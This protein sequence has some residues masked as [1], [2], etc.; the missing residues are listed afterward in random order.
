[1]KAVSDQL[2]AV[3][4]ISELAADRF[5]TIR[6]FWRISQL[7]SGTDC[8]QLT[9][10]AKRGGTERYASPNPPELQIPQN[11]FVLH[12]MRRTAGCISL[13]PCVFA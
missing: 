5:F 11:H 1:M 7:N 13:R 2:P 4:S 10:T 6:V 12:K 9:C 3:S 8:C